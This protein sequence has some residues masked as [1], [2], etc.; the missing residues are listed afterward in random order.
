MINSKTARYAQSDCTIAHLLSFSHFFIKMVDWFF[1]FH[2]FFSVRWCMFCLASAAAY[3]CKI[4]F[5]L[6]CVCARA[7]MGYSAKFLDWV[8]GQPGFIFAFC[9]HNPEDL[10]K[11]TTLWTLKFFNSS[12]SFGSS[13]VCESALSWLLGEPTRHCGAMVRFT[14]AGC[15]QIL[16]W[17]L[18]LSFTLCECREIASHI[19]FSHLLE[20]GYCEF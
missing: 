5:L 17:I 12:F 15:K 14:G 20:Y 2:S 9:T 16:F 11:T 8:L 1:C 6:L 10:V 7:C 3:N 18:V 13:E 19:V 4:E